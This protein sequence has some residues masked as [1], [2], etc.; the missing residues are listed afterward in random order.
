MPPNHEKHDVD[1][2]KLTPKTSENKPLDF[3]FA[4]IDNDPY[5]IA[6]TCLLIPRFSNHVLTG[7]ITTYLNDWLIKICISYG[8]KL[9]FIDIQPEFLH[10]VMHVPMNHSPAYF[11]RII[12]KITSTN[13]F[14]EFPRFK[15]D[16]KSDEFWTTNNL[17]LAGKR[18]HPKPMIEE[19]I[20]TTRRQQGYS[21]WK[22][23]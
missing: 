20:K 12:K 13:I 9:E 22:L 18:P 23:K 8:W 3:E 16:N 17:I 6:Y 2:E 10:W 7:D 15:K 1:Y 5:V 11:I 14:S 21:S 4:R 19:F